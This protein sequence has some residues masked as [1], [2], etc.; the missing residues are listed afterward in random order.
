MACDMDKKAEINEVS[1]RQGYRRRKTRHNII[2]ICP[3]GSTAKKH[4]HGKQEETSHDVS[5]FCDDVGVSKNNLYVPNAVF[6]RESKHLAGV[7][8]ACSRI[9]PLHSA[10]AIG[11]LLG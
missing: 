2:S 6:S 1:R 11:I 9:L 10:L 4:A 8:E 3:Y 7:L 5:Y